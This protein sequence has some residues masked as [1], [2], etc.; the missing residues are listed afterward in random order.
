MEIL[1]IVIFLITSVIAT[2]L[3]DG[4]VLVLIS[5]VA[6]IIMLFAYQSKMD[7]KIKKYEQQ[8]TDLRV[9][10]IILNRRLLNSQFNCKTTKEIPKETIDAVKLA[11]KVSHPDNGGKQE[12]FIK[13]RELYNKLTNKIS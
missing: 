6:I 3:T 12:D 11:M 4:S 1:I 8:C 2:L 13:Y 9:R 10:N 5:Q 7:E